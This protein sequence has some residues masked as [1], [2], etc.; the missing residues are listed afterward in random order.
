VAIEID[1][2]RR[3]ELTTLMAE[4]KNDHEAAVKNTYAFLRQ[5]WMGHIVTED[6]KY[7]EFLKSKGVE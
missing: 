7:G 5:W 6:K 4:S 2:V 1:E 3:S